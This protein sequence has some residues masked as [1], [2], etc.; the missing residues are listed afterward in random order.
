MKKDKYMIEARRVL[1]RLE[2]FL[3]ACECA[4]ISGFVGICISVFH[5][6]FAGLFAL[7]MFLMIFRYKRKAIWNEYREEEKDES[8]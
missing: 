3:V 5:K 1:R 6:E 7:V 4:V 8:S 2:K